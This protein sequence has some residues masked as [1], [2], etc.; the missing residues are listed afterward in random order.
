MTTFVFD[1]YGTLFNL[2]ALESVATQYLHDPVLS[3]RVCKTWR[4][5]HLDFAWNAVLMERYQDFD[6]L[7]KMAM[8]ASLRAVMGSTL[9]DNQ[10]QQLTE[11]LLDANQRLPIYDDVKSTLDALA[12]AHR[13]AILS[14]GTFRSLQSITHHAGILFSFDYIL[15]S[16][17]IRTYKPSRSAYQLVLDTFHTTKDDVWFV[18]SNDWDIAGAKSFGFHTVWCNRKQQPYT[19]VGFAPDHIVQSLTDLISHFPA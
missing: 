19:G 15:S 17:P 4:Q 2:D 7:A 11:S 10:R 1:A 5:K 3:A 13:L 9:T 16:D 8:D 12:T 18:S 6:K 14:N